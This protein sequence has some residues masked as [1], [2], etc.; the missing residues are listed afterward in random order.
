MSGLEGFGRFGFG[1]FG[2]KNGRFGVS[3]STFRRRF[4]HYRRVGRRFRRYRRFGRRFSD[5]SDVV[6][7][8]PD[9]VFDVFGRRFSDV[10]Q[11]LDQTDGLEDENRTILTQIWM[12]WT[13]SMQILTDRL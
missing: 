2:R 11:P 6:L 12:I 8:S 13:A 3:L 5:R 1:R 4:R 7:D 10:G 9:V